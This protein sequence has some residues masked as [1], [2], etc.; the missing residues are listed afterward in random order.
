MDTNLFEWIFGRVH[1][2]VRD[3][4]VI[5]FLFLL[6]PVLVELMDFHGGVALLKQVKRLNVMRKDRHF[7]LSVCTERR[8][9]RTESPCTAVD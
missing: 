4:L 6:P 3:A 9:R 2:S 1:E 8:E 5:I 7:F